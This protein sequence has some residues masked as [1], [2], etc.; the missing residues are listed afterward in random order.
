MRRTTCLL[1]AFASI[2]ACS[3]GSGT[4]TPASSAPKTVTTFA[5][6]PQFPFDAT[7][8]NEFPGV[9]LERRLEMAQEV[10]DSI[11]SHGDDIVAWL[12]LSTTRHDLVSF[13]ASQGTFSAFVGL[14]VKA[15]CPQYLVQLQG[16]LGVS[17]PSSSS[18]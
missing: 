4:A 2:A 14:A 12:H 15:I 18:S 1:I 10:C 6:A 8:A 7:S 17:P 11:K 3:G 13:T 9:S 5:G 16:A